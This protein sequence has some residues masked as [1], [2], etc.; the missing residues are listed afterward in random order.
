MYAPAAFAVDDPAEIAAMIARAPL[1]TLVVQ[2]ESG[3]EAAH[4]PV[5]YDAAAG[6]LIGHLAREN[7]VARARP[8]QALAIFRGASAYVSPGFYPSKH[9]HGRVVPTWNYEAVHIHGALEWIDDPAELLT[10]V[11]DLS[12]RF[13]QDRPS[14]WAL[15]D[16]PEP[17]V[18]GLLHAIV[19]V[20]LQLATIEATRKLSQNRPEA[21]RLGVLQGLSTGPAETRAVAALMTEQSNG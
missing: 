14:P 1:A 21:D 9:E 7:P 16:A 15:S 13:E 20:R 4:L 19:G 18:Q 12:N 2:T 8:Q 11:T 3:L 6:L 5:L 10:I 17:Y